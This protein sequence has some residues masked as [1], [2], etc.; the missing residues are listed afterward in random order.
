V[1]KNT[2]HKLLWQTPAGEWVGQAG[3]GLPFAVCQGRLFHL[4]DARAG[5]AVPPQALGQDRSRDAMPLD[6]RARECMDGR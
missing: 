6:S 1:S 5:S 4:L 2:L 3:S